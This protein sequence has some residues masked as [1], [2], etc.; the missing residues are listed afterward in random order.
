MKEEII[1]QNNVLILRIDSQKF[2][3]MGEM[4]LEVSGRDLT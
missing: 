3:T 4:E 1:W 2:N